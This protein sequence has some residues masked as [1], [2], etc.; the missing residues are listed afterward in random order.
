MEVTIIEVDPGK[1]ER[2]R[3]LKL[4]IADS[5]LDGMGRHTS[6]PVLCRDLFPRRDVFPL[7]PAPVRNYPKGEGSARTQKARPRAAVLVPQR[8]FGES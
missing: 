2:V 6:K 3:K 4:L 8:H 1:D 7:V 5:T